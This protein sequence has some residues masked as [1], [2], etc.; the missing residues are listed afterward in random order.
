[1]SRSPSV[2]GSVLNAHLGLVYAFLY[3]PILVLILLSF[4]KS[5]LPTAWGGVPEVVCGAGAQLGDI[6]GGAQH[7]IVALSATFIACV[8]GTLLA[9]GIEM[10]RKGDDKGKW[11]TPC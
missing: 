11:S 9:L 10:R 7:L 3:V 2:G 6:V 5:G 4:N 8:L 1:M